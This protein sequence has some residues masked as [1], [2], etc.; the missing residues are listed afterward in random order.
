[1]MFDNNKQEDVNELSG[2]EELSEITLVKD[3]MSFEY[4]LYD[5]P[6]HLN[7]LVGLINHYMAGLAGVEKQHGK[8]QQLRLVDGLANQEN[9]EVL[10][11]VSGNRAVGLAVCFIH[12]SIFDIKPYMYIQD[13][14]VEEEFRNKGFGRALLEKLI[15]SSVEREFSKITLEVCEDS[16][17]AQSLFESMGF[18]NIDP[19]RK[20]LTMKL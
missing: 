13:L 10:F 6:D 1:M 4:C 18:E 12:F 20:F 15:E 16:R 9:A 7:A 8:L 3:M 17:I 14:I 5:N 19:V 11:V 2:Y